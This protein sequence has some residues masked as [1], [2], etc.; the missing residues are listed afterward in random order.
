MP[1]AEWPVDYNIF[2]REKTGSGRFPGPWDAEIGR[3]GFACSGA[4]GRGI[5]AAGDGNRRQSS[6]P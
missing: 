4:N 5:E 1:R 6:G 3:D 2:T